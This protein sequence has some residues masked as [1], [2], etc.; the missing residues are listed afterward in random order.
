M[1]KIENR[2]V[3]LHFIVT[4]STPFLPAVMDGFFAFSGKSAK[5]QS[6]A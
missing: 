1:A 6:V 2:T 4:M 5:K 3:T